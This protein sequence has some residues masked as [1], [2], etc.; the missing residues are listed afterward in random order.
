MKQDSR[1]NR[2]KSLTTALGALVLA[3]LT[4][5]SSGPANLA[6]SRIQTQSAQGTAAAFKAEGTLRRYKQA[7]QKVQTQNAT[8]TAQRAGKSLYRSAADDAAAAPQPERPPIPVNADPAASA[9]PAAPSLQPGQQPYTPPGAPQIP[10]ASPSQQPLDGVGTQPNAPITGV[11]NGVTPTN[12]HFR[13]EDIQWHLR[14]ISAARAWNV[15]EGNPD[16]T[17]AVIDT[18]V[19]YQHPAFR[20]RM[21]NGYNFADSNMDPSDDVAHGTH[22]AGIIAGNDGNIRG[23]APGVKIL[24]IKVFNKTGFAQGDYVLA[25]AIRYATQNGADIINLSLGSP[26]LMDCGAYSDMMRALNSAID[27]AYANGVT[28]VTAAGNEGYDFIY[29][30]CS[31]QQNVNQI[32]VIATTEL[33]RLAPF[34]NYSNLTHPKAISAPGVNI[35]S[36]VPRFMV[37]DA[38][39]CDLPYD[40]MDGTSMASPVVAGSLALIRSAMYQDYV[41]T[42][43]RRQAANRMQGPLLS[44]KDFFHGGAEVAR[45]QLSMAVTPA[46][47]SERLLFTFTNQPGRVVPQGMI[48]EGFRDPVFG[49]GRI[50]V[51][52]A[53]EA[54]AKVFTAAG[55]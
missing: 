46:Q 27:E 44:F 53:T 17:V 22:V 43:R 9:D 42:M 23:V 13:Y 25:R 30:R 14:K 29:G 45:S 24:A 19:D 36:T 26:T 28:V 54:A 18:G 21:L 5:C 41:A 8:I 15:T 33:D 52:A 20:G 38:T 7:Q 4:A 35:F 40:Y 3:A 47:L 12:P 31:V 6:G 1:Q 11:P 48:Y 10:N 50:D 32:P 51:G 39:H 34:S 55:L 16:L 2:K 37:C 49:Y